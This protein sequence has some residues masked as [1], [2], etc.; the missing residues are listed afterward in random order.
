MEHGIH[1]Y[2]P[3]SVLRDSQHSENRYAVKL[4]LCATAH[5]DGDDN[6]WS[7]NKKVFNKV[8]KHMWWHSTFN[9]CKL[10]LQ[11]NSL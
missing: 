9:I 7:D 8:R 11:Q 1:F 2:V 6:S 4:I 3:Y 5:I 10:L